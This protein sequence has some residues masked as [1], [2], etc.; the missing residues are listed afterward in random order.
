MQDTTPHDDLPDEFATI[1]VKPHWS[2]RAKT[3]R[4]TKSTTL[5]LS[6][7]REG[8]KEIVMKEITYGQETTSE[9]LLNLI[10]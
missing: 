10:V 8:K 1:F 7:E 2:E 5:V 3:E 9:V 6:Y 4:R